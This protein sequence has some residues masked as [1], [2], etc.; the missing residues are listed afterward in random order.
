MLVS[1][2]PPLEAFSDLLISEALKSTYQCHNNITTEFLAIFKQSRV[3][4]F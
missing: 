2:K 1:T 4:N 3:Q